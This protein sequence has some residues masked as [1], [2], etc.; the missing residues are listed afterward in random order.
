M[1]N[2][3]RHLD[4]DTNW[5]EADSRRAMTRVAGFGA[6]LMVVSAIATAFL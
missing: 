3:Q 2:V 4:T 5:T 1:E 6:G